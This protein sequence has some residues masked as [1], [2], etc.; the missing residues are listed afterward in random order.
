[1]SR[2]EPGHRRKRPPGPRRGSNRTRTSCSLQ[3]VRTDR[4]SGRVGGG[5]ALLLQPAQ[6]GQELGPGLGI[7]RVG[8]DA[9]HRTDFQTLR[10]VEMADALR[11]QRRIDHIDGFA[12]RDRPVRADRLADVTVD[13]KLV[14][15]KRHGCMQWPPRTLPAGTAAT[16]MAGP[17]YF[18]MKM[19]STPAGATA[20]STRPFSAAS[21]MNSTRTPSM[22]PSGTFSNARTTIS[23]TRLDS[24]PA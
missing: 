10:L 20:C 18:S 17:A 4:G 23:A 24:W 11:A 5:R 6:L 16:R 9:F 8:V 13:T 2:P 15:L 14:D 7:V 3:M 22:L 19:Y 12:L 21:P 1:M